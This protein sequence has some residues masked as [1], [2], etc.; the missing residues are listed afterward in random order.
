[1]IDRGD[2]KVVVDTRADSL[3]AL[4][5]GH[6]EIGYEGSWMEITQASYPCR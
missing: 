2:I 5:V 6:N 1:M 3:R 4:I